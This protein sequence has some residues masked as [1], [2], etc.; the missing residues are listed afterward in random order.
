MFFSGQV[1]GFPQ[2]N[3]SSFPAAAQEELDRKGGAGADGRYS[4]VS[5]LTA[6]QLMDRN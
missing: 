1:Q 4:A 6:H 2:S 3:V 5:V